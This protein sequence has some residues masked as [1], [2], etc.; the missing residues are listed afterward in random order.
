MNVIL[1]FLYLAIAVFK[2]FISI[3][4][5]DIC[6]QDSYS[7]ITYKLRFNWFESI[8]SWWSSKSSAAKCSMPYPTVQYTDYAT[9]F[10]A[11]N[12]IYPYVRIEQ[13]NKA[14]CWSIFGDIGTGCR[15][16]DFETINFNNTQYR[17][18]HIISTRDNSGPWDVAVEIG[19]YFKKDGNT[20]QLRLCCDGFILSGGA[21]WRTLD[22]GLSVSSITFMTEDNRQYN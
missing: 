15:H 3:T 12:R 2:L 11:F 6:F 9:S 1:S 8:G 21:Y 22:F 10:D 5:Y 16:Y 19:P 14:V 17:Y 7:P 13:C 4:K 18:E 20:L